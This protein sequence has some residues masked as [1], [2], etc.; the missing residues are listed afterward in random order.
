MPSDERQRVSAKQERSVAR[1]FGATQHSGSGSGAKRLDMHNDDAII[2][3]KTVLQGKK[4]I[5]IRVSDLKLLLY[6][7]AVQDRDA[8]LHVQIDE[9][10]WV[11]IPE[12]DYLS[13]DL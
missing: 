3:C 10:K 9:Q 4:Q 2:E 6:Q 8:V 5:T 1:R 12:S 7:A 11:L 13:R